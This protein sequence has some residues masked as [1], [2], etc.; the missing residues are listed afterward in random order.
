[1]RLD[2][3][4]WSLQHLMVNGSS[5]SYVIELEVKMVESYKYNLWLH[6]SMAAMEQASYKQFFIVKYIATWGVVCTEQLSQC[7]PVCSG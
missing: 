6:G 4:K 7:G 1:M 5:D 3:L 2:G